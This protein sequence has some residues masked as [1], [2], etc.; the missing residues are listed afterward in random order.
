MKVKKEKIE[1]KRKRCARPD[2]VLTQ[3]MQNEGYL[4]CTDAA[5]RIG[6]HKATLYRWIRDGVVRAVDFNGA[7]FVEWGSVVDHMGE[8]AQILKIQR[9]LGP[10][11]S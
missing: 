3:K 5:S 10:S 6:I 9:T 1:S 8:V 4:L 11:S 7:Y 2:S